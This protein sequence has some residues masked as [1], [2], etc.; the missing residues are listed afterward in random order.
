[1]E[2]HVSPHYEGILRPKPPHG[3]SRAEILIEPIDF[4]T[5]CDNPVLME[6]Q[7]KLKTVGEIIQFAGGPSA[8]ARR[9]GIAPNRVSMWKNRSRFPPDTYDAWQ[10][11]LKEKKATAPV[12]L[13][14]QKQV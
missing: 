1:M 3:Y 4:I 12:E 2:R 6:S 9:F 8:V 7:T 5:P 13:W 10:K 14:Q 11:I